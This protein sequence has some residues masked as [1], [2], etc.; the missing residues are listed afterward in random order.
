MTLFALFSIPPSSTAP[1]RIC[2]TRDPRPQFHVFS[3]HSPLATRHFLSVLLCVSAFGCLFFS[4]ART[5]AQDIDKPLQSID[6]EVTGFSFAPD[7]RIVY[8][9]RRNFKTK[10]YD[11]EHD[12]IWLMEPNGKKRRLLE[13]PK[14]TRGNEL[15]SY[16]A[17]AFHWSPNGRFILAQLFTTSVNEDSGR[18]ED[19]YTT[20]A[21]D[22]NGHELH[23]GKGESVIKDCYDASFLQD[24]NTIVYL[25]EALQP[26]MLFSF[27]YSSIATGAAGPAFEGR[28]F[29]DSVRL[30]RTNAAIAVERDRAMSGPPRLQRLELLAQDDQEIATLDDYQGGLSLSPSG[31]KIAYFIDRE[32]LEV[33]D[34][35]APDH[36]ARL[37]VGLGLVQ[38]A[39]DE[40]RIL[41][42]RAVERKSGD[43]VWITLPPLAA[44]RP[45]QPVPVIQP[46]PQPILHGISFRDFAV[47]PDG[48]FLA[49]VA[50]GRRNLQLFPLIG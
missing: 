7:G 18:A 29:I 46:T 2:D 32:V 17:D 6:E 3:R 34:L 16:V 21:L 25:T 5:P 8:G 26:R 39:P 36:V 43:V 15:F 37:R 48:R 30:P 41:L 50:P 19:S 31:S 13:G 12:D 49:V 44:P 33:R 40:N 14:F 1:R 23:L 47:S 45:G 9:V 4:P 38:W 10:K 20:L 42:K 35:A 24:N 27:R 28:T 22:D 11:L